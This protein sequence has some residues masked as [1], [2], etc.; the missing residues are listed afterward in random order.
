MRLFYG[1]RWWCYTII[2]I[3]TSDK[4][5]FF[6]CCLYWSYLNVRIQ[7]DSYANRLNDLCH[8]TLLTFMEN[9]FCGLC[10]EM[11]WTTT[12]TTTNSVHL[13]TKIEFFVGEKRPFDGSNVTLTAGKESPNWIN[14]GSTM[15][16]QNS[17]NVV[18]NAKARKEKK[19]KIMAR[20]AISSKWSTGSCI[21]QVIC[22]LNNKLL[23]LL[24]LLLYQS[25]AKCITH[26]HRTHNSNHQTTTRQPIKVLSSHDCWHCCCCC[27]CCYFFSLTL[28][29]LL[30]CSMNF[31]QCGDGNGN[32]NGNH[33][34]KISFMHTL[35]FNKKY[36]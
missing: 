10:N 29:S 5:H 26:T 11:I 20:N 34:L 14:D 27:I 18:M 2:S 13:D 23:L 19:K 21:C 16:E 6:S 28:C 12:T 9:Y 32:V 15:T 33:L 1:L 3:S 31:L 22:R 36:L 8:D 30:C 17:S 7:L 24:L 4:I 35:I 25:K